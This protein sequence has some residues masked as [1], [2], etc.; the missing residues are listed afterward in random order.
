MPEPLASPI[1]ILVVDDHAVVRTAL[2]MVIQNQPS[3]TMIGEATSRAE[4]L[5]LNS[6]ERPDIVLLDIDLGSENG[7]DFIPE[8]LAACQCR[9]IVLTGV[10]DPEVH[11]RAVKLGAMG[12]VQKE[13]AV[14]VLIDAIE[15][16][17]AG[18]AW[19]DPSLTARVLSE[20]STAGKNKKA[21]PEE[22]KIASLTD[23]EREVL[24]LVSE[25]LKNKEIAERLFISEWTVRHHITSI[26]SK[27]DV[28]DRVELILYAYRQGIA[29]PPASRS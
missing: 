10:R 2:R 4:A 27:L 12:L 26:F 3:M 1:R 13:R 24:T 21:D 9:V 15:R 5:D 22:A 23:R 18:E 29:I 6:R 25:G 8:L 28:S 14:D 11:Y 19:L 20:V 17:H 7:L 16:V